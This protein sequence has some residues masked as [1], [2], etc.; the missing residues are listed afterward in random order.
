MRPTTSPARGL[1]LLL[2]WGVAATTSSGCSFLFVDAPPSNAKRLPAFTCTNSNAL[3]VVDGVIAGLAT[4]S[5]V[6]ALTDGSHQTYDAATQTWSKSS[7]DSS[8]AAVAGAWAALFAASAFVGHSRVSEC[9][10]AT[11]DLMQRMSQGAPGQGFAPYPSCPPPGLRAAGA[12]LR[13]GVDGAPAPGSRPRPGSRPQL[14]ARGR[15]PC[16]RRP[17]PTEAAKP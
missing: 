4:L 9:K 14:P 12:R 16:P 1:A 7:P 2:C 13:S 3:P 17:R 10:E 5:V 15:A 11:V 6:G 8:T